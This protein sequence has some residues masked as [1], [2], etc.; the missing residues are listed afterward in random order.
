M[1]KAT[2]HMVQHNY[3]HVEIEM[4]NL[5][6]SETMNDKLHPKTEKDVDNDFCRA[7]SLYC[8]FIGRSKDIKVR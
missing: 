7:I 5:H 8:E 6:V 2:S 4:D 1:W 3:L